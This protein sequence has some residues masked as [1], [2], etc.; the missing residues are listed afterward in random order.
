MYR[1]TIFNLYLYNFISKYGDLDIKSN[2]LIDSSD[3]AIV[4]SHEGYQGKLGQDYTSSKAL[5]KS[6]VKIKFN[7]FNTTPPR[8]LI[9][10]QGNKGAGR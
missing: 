5:K 8:P 10:R 2:Y 1:F 4:K 9:I 3:K 6:I 7:N